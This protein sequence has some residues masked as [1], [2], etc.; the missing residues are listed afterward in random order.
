ME[1]GDLFGGTA[2]T[3]LARREHGKGL[4]IFGCLARCLA[5]LLQ[6]LAPGADI[7]GDLQLRERALDGI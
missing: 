7:F 6:F 4:E 5:R 2:Q 1:L 3:G